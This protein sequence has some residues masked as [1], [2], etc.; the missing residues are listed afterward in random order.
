M[1][2]KYYKS[3]TEAM[4]NFSVFS[5]MTAID[6]VV[7]MFILQKTEYCNS[8]KPFGGQTISI[9]SKNKKEICEKLQITANKFEDSIRT[10]VNGGLI[11]RIPDKRGMYQVNPFIWGFGREED[12][13]K[14]RDVCMKN[15]WFRDTDAKPSKLVKTKAVA[16][17]IPIESK[18]TPK[19][20]ADR[21]INRFMEG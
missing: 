9:S 7:L 1:E 13:E 19:L 12:V 11:R 20:V 6:H 16:N 18:S 3:Y 15:E 10:F 5:K 8:D 17:I 2:R 4:N 14:F 21:A